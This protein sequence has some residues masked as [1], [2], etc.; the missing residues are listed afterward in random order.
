MWD[1]IS[2]FLIFKDCPCR[3]L[4]S[5]NRVMKQ[6]HQLFND[7]DDDDVKNNSNEMSWKII[8][9]QEN[10]FVSTT[11]NLVFIKNSILLEVRC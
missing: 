5:N 8:L 3:F 10:A 4:I 11:S 1:H 9:F 2:K 7:D 6:N